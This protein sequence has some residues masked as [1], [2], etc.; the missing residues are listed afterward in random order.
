MV[1][2]HGYCVACEAFIAS[3]GAWSLKGAGPLSFSHTQSTGG[4]ADVSD[5]QALL[6]R[7][8][9]AVVQSYHRVTP[10]PVSHGQHTH[11]C[12]EI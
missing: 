6:H 2:F 4:R 11:T 7:S 9:L 12:G 5:S 10:P 1:V 8:A 3:T